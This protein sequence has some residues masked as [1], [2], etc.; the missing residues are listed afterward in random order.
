MSGG[1]KSCLE[2]QHESDGSHGLVGAEEKSD[3]S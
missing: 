2:R 1:P 3:V